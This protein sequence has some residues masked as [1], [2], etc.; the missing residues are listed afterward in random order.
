MEYCW[1]VGWNRILEIAQRMCSAPILSA[2]VTMISNLHTLGVRLKWFKA[3]ITGFC[4][5]VRFDL[6]LSGFIG[7]S[8]KGLHRRLASCIMCLQNFLMQSGP[9]YRVVGFLAFPY[10]NS[11]LMHQP[12]RV[13][14]LTSRVDG[15]PGLL[16]GPDIGSSINSKSAYIMNGTL[17]WY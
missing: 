7:T 2:V 5:I 1:D 3:N 16:D 15:S 11:D 9:P 8:G 17:N 10:A 13:W 6:R 4:F 12:D 14:I